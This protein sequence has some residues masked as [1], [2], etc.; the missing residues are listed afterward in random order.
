MYVNKNE[1]H[2]LL[3]ILLVL[4]MLVLIKLLLDWLLQLCIRIG[5]VGDQLLDPKVA[6]LQ[7]DLHDVDHL[8]TPQHR[9]SMASEHLLGAELAL[10]HL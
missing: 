8:V 4:L 10:I 3:L 1:A 5:K 2:V 9:R 7:T 6:L